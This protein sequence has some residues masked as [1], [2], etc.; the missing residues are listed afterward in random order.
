[1]LEFSIGSQHY[2]TLEFPLLQ[3]KHEY[4]IAYLSTGFNSSFRR[5]DGGA[6]WHPSLY[7]V[8]HQQ[9]CYQVR[10]QVLLCMLTVFVSPCFS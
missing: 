4:K 7:T 10:Y 9:A 3:L 2:V 1:M 5:K 6:K 8:D